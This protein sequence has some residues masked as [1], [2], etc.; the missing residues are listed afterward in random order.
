MPLARTREPHRQ[1]LGQSPNHRICRFLS[2]TKALS[3]R[4]QRPPSPS[5]RRAG[6]ARPS[7]SAISCVSGWLC[8]FFRLPHVLS[9]PEDRQPSLS[10][11][12]RILHPSGP[13]DGTRRTGTPSPTL[14]R[15]IPWKPREQR[16]WT[17]CAG[18]IPNR[19]V[20][21][22]RPPPSCGRPPPSFFGLFRIGSSHPR[23]LRPCLNG[24]PRSVR[25]P[26]WFMRGTRGCGGTSPQPPLKRLSS[27]GKAQFHHPAGTPAG[28]P[29]R[30][31]SIWVPGAASRLD[32]DSAR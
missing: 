11:Q 23:R 30:L 24:I 9:P 17:S 4:S 2:G 18:P 3:S 14:P 1:S 22:P 25:N 6:L 31:W 29:R 26:P 10:T 27:Q 7:C 13:R 28:G 15:R 32:V 8:A 16:R 12:A 5:Q 19:P 20:S 21:T